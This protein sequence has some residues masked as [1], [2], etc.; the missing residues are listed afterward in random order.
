M[1]S[2]EVEEDLNK[3]TYAEIEAGMCFVNHPWTDPAAGKP[4]HKGH[5]LG[6]TV[7]LTEDKPMVASRMP[8]ELNV[9]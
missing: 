1:K 9:I 3:A 6:N 5:F 8:T 2:T 4:G 7:V